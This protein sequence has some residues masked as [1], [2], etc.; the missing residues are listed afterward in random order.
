MNRDLHGIF[1]R[2]QRLSLG[3]KVYLVAELNFASLADLQTV[4]KEIRPHPLE[5]LRRQVAEAGEGLTRSERHLLTAAAYE[6][7]ESWPPSPLTAEGRRLLV[8]TPQG[9]AALLAVAIRQGGGTIGDEEAVEVARAMSF[10]D[11]RR[12]ASVVFGT[13]P[14]VEL[15]NLLDPGGGRGGTGGGETNWV[16]ILAEMTAD[17]FCLPLSEIERWTPTQLAM[18]RSGGKFDPGQAGSVPADNLKPEEL[19]ALAR[20]RRA[21]FRGESLPDN[22]SPDATPH[23]AEPT[24]EP[25][26]PPRRPPGPMPPNRGPSLFEI[27]RNA[28]AA[29]AGGGP[30][31]QD[32]SEQ[33]RPAPGVS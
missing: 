3:G 7:G 22:S 15:Y 24:L 31:R 25:A 12:F 26:E 1:S 8:E 5:S 2:P 20:R 10:E 13:S 18:V 6:D 19:A 27:A 17:P 9:S 4:L 16:S 14:Q 32:W 23:H 21:I 28:T 11:V 30:P 33:R 29:G